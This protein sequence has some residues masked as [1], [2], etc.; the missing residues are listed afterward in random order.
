MEENYLSY[1]TVALYRKPDTTN[2]WGEL[3]TTFVNEDSEYYYF[4]AVSPGFSLFVVLLD[5]S[6]CNNNNICEPELGED[7]VNCQN[8]CTK[9][10]GFFE[11][12]KAYLVNGILIVLA[13]T[14]V[15]VFL[16]IRIKRKKVKGEKVQKAPPQ[17]DI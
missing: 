5:L 17:Q 4:S 14:I 16:V 1:E 15:I 12:I 11:T 6:I 9:E 13:V 2:I 10:E 8:D 7:G 3:N